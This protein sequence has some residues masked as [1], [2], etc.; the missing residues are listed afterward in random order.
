M[1]KQKR[2]VVGW[3]GEIVIFGKQ[4]RGTEG[5]SARSMTLLEAKRE[6]ATMYAGKKRYISWFPW[7]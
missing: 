7:S 2:Y 4:P 1:K 6:L 5:H 3:V